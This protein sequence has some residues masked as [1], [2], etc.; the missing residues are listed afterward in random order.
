MKKNTLLYLDEHLVRQA[1]NYDINLSKVAEQAIKS[2]LAQHRPFVFDA[3]EHLKSLTCYFLP[4]RIELLDIKN[5]GPIKKR[6]MEFSSLNIIL[7]KNAS[8]KSIL[9]SAI[10]HVA[11]RAAIDGDRFFSN[12]DAWSIRIKK[13]DERNILYAGARNP[14]PT[15]HGCLLVDD[16]FERLGRDYHVMFMD[17]LKTLKSQLILTCTKLPKIKRS[18]LNIIEI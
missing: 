4:F 18:G 16:A 7:G 6:S 3:K 1:K 10:N 12:M 15:S 9:L 8:G 2:E 14:I 11:T 17:Y 5:I 13:A